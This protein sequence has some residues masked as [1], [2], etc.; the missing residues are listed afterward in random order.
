[1]ISSVPIIDLSKPRSVPEQVSLAVTHGAHWVDSPILFRTGSENEQIQGD[2]LLG[3]GEH[4]GTAQ[5]PAPG[6]SSWERGHIHGPL[7]DM[8][9]GTG[10]RVGLR[11]GG[12][13]IQDFSYIYLP[14]MG[15]LPPG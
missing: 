1:M 15:V 5:G 10:F 13:P 6:N 3:N 9:L 14:Q 12:P 11:V 8:N 7:G 2:D 4:E